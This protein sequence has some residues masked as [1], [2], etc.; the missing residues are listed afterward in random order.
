MDVWAASEH[1]LQNKHRRLKPKNKK[2]KRSKKYREFFD[3]IP[4][5][6]ITPHK[7]YDQEKKEKQSPGKIDLIKFMQMYQLDEETAR[8]IL[9]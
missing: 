2:R 9:N 8:S 6:H 5:P 3:Q 4:V 1:F 7:P